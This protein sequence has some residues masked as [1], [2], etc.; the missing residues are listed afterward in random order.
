MV[1]EKIK[2]GEVYTALESGSG[3]VEAYITTNSAEINID[4]KRPT[5]IICPGGG[6]RFTSD[7]EAEP[8]ALR[9]MAE[10]FNAIV[11]RY[12]VVPIRY[13]QQLLELAATVDYARKMK[14]KWNVDNENIIVCGFSAGGHLAASLGTCLLY[15]SPSPRD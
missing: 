11:L 2:L 10:G 3:V 9:F 5:V 12:S 14:D 4:R 1:F 15:T 7:R 8:V 6:Y 13:P